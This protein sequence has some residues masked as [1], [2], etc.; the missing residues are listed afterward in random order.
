MN[1]VKNK[2]FLLLLV[3]LFQVFTIKAQNKFTRLHGT[4]NGSAK[5]EIIKRT[6][7]LQP[8]K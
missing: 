3:L 8:Q 6:E 5:T 4:Y 1:T 2:P 7:V